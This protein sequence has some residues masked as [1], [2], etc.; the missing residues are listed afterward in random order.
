MCLSRRGRPRCSCDRV[1]CD[2]AYRPVCAHDGHTYD[3]DCWRQQAECQQQ[4]SIPAKHQ[5]PCG[6]HRGRRPRQAGP[7]L[8]RSSRA[9]SIQVML[10]LGCGP[11]PA[12]LGRPGR[13]DGCHRALGGVQSAR[14]VPVA[15]WGGEGRRQGLT[16]AGSLV[17]ACGRPAQQ[18]SSPLRP[19]LRTHAAPV[20]TASQLGLERPEMVCP[21]WAGALP[22]S[23]SVPFGRSVHLSGLSLCVCLLSSPPPS[24][25][26]PPL[27]SSSLTCC[28]D[29][30]PRGS[31]PAT[32][33]P[34]PEVCPPRG[35]GGGSLLP[36]LVVLRASG[37]T[38]PPPCGPGC[39]SGLQREREREPLPPPICM[40]VPGLL[41]VKVQCPGGLGKLALPEPT[42]VILGAPTF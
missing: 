19:T 35:R 11:V 17:P 18:P 1:I 5:G 4:R 13:A 21:A 32:R 2:G 27:V 30:V 26:A 3:N 25:L 38:P 34:Q 8:H 12:T 14:N 40:D 20:D 39:G 7:V 24:L 10:L 6:E 23:H 29:E 16:C 33:S 28:Q 36:G 31:A 22:S 9:I 37:Q 15:P 42:E 41:V